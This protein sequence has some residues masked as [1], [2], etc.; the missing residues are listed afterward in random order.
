MLVTMMEHDNFVGRVVTGRVKAGSVGVGDKIHAIGDEGKILEAG[1][2]TKLY[3]RKGMSRVEHQGRV[4][5]GDICSIGGLAAPRVT[6]TISDLGITEGIPALPI[7]PPTISMTFSVNDSPLAG[8]SGKKLTSQMIR[9]RLRT[10]TENNVSVSLRKTE[11]R[12]DA[13][14]VLG[15]GEMQLGILIEN[16]RRE[17]YEM[18]VAPPQVVYQICEETGKRFEPMKEFMNLALTP[19]LTLIEGL[20]LWRRL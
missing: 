15:R 1:R 7:D 13:V 6:H 4:Y 16:M 9:D 5:A 20:S 10:E 19:I 12:D 11:G 17:G 3:T 18:S 14:D 8:K 2:V